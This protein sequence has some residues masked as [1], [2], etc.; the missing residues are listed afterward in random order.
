MIQL[1]DGKSAPNGHELLVDYWE[2]VGGAPPGGIDHVLNEEAG[3]ETMLENRLAGSD[4]GFPGN[5]TDRGVSL[6]RP[7]AEIYAPSK[8]KA[9]S[10]LFVLFFFHQKLSV[11]LQCRPFS[12]V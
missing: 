7:A 1:P 8:K 12:H 11:S 3:V 10:Y 9:F 6:T 4:D 5:S 2:L